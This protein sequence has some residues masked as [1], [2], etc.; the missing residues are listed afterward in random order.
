MMDGE[1]REA[2][3]KEEEAARELLGARRAF[4]AEVAKVKR[5]LEAVLEAG[6]REAAEEVAAAKERTAREE[7]GRLEES[8]L[9]V[10]PMS[11]D[12]LA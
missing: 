5:E 9:K 7:E 12:I 3:R 10:C 2:A 1:R 8:R 4:E 11:L 6:R